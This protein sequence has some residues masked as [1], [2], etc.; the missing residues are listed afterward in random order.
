MRR[1]EWKSSSGF[2][3]HSLVF[4]VGTMVG[5]HVV[6]E[7]LVVNARFSS[8]ESSRRSHRVALGATGITGERLHR[9]VGLCGCP[10]KFLTGG[11]WTGEDLF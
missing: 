10:C 8:T 9:S 5:C 6:I 11:H 3:D 7:P 2:S 4:L 1:G